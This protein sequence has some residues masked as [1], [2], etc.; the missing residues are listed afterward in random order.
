MG[1]SAVP[2]YRNIGGN[3]LQTE[4]NQKQVI[5]CFFCFSSKKM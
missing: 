1:Y 3:N 2:Y 4:T 5:Q